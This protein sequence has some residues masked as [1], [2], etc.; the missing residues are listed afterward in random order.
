MK[1]SVVAAA[2]LAV[3]AFC[4]PKANA[5]PVAAGVRGGV[6]VGIGMSVPAPSA[7]YAAPA[8]V[9]APPVAVAPVAVAPPYYYAPRVALHAR[10]PYSRPYFRAGFAWGNRCYG[11]RYWHR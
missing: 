3:T 9:C 4:T 10:Y 7:Y 5:W 8:P 11:G 6:A 1:T 2:A